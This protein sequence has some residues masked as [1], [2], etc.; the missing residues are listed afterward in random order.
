MRWETE[1]LVPEPPDTR[2]RPRWSKWG[3]LK[4]SKREAEAVTFDDF[5]IE[6][7]NRV[8]KVNQY[9]SEHMLLPVTDYRMVIL[10]DFSWNAGYTAALRAVKS[11]DIRRYISQH[12]QRLSR[13]QKYKNY[14]DGWA[15]RQNT[16]VSLFNEWQN[17]YA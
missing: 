2:G 7:A 10:L 5:L 4:S 13:Q 1:S 12:Y 17:V 14:A 9:W 3:L 15:A 6:V 16:W 8:I 11:G